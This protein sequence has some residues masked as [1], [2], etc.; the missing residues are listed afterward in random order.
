MVESTMD[1][2]LFFKHFSGHIS[3][4]CATYVD[5][6]LNAGDEKFEKLTDL[7]AKRFQCRKKELDHIQFAGIEI[8]K[9]KDGFIVHQK[10]YIK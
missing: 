6:K 2:A 5:D 3:G 7:T 10:Q 9:V 8:D 4:L 1:S